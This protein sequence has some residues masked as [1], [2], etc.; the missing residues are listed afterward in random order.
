MQ[1]KFFFKFR[2]L[3]AV[4]DKDLVSAHRISLGLG[5]GKRGNSSTDSIEK[6]FNVNVIVNTFYGK[7]G[8]IS[9][10]EFIEELVTDYNFGLLG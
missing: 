2:I 3:M 6:F 5:V 7:V 10:F 4:T 8:F 9:R 1:Q